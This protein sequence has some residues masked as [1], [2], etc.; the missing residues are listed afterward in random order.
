MDKDN[1][2]GFTF[3]DESEI[4]DKINNAAEI[5]RAQGAAVTEKTYAE[6]LSAV[7]SIIVP[8][9]QNLMKDPD[10]VMIKWPNRKQIVEAQLNKVL[11]ITKSRV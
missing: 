11:A 1:D 5:A 3:H 9:L 7:E 4:D 10:K 6:R 8:F 2:F